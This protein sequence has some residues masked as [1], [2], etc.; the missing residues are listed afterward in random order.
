MNFLMDSLMGRMGVQLMFPIK[1]PITIDTMLNFDGNFD[2][3][4]DGDITGKQSFSPLVNYKYTLKSEE[5]LVLY[6]CRL[7]KFK[8]YIL[9]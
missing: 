2:G 6:Q 9:K 8:F 3:H 7:K 1:V 5:W 4:S